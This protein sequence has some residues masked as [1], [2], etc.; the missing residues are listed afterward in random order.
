MRR[1]FAVYVASMDDDAARAW[2]EREIAATTAA[3]ARGDWDQALAAFVAGLVLVVAACGNHSDGTTH[4]ETDPIGGLLGG[5]PPMPRPKA[6]TVCRRVPPPVLTATL[7]DAGAAPRGLL[8]YSP[9]AGK[10][11]VEV[12]YD[13]VSDVTAPP[14]HEGGEVPHARLPTVAVIGD[15]AV[16][17]GDPAHYVVTIARIE[18]RRAGDDTSVEEFESM[19]ELLPA[20][21]GATIMGTVGPTGVAGET[22][23]CVSSA[24]PRAVLALDFVRNAVPVWPLLPTE[25]VPHGRSCGP[26]T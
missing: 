26:P 10:Q 8:R 16:T 17:P 11:H 18:A 5:P 21:K 15:V 7:V 12:M 25:P 22:T 9:R 19:K 2:V 23:L 3:A 13:R 6:E 20:A 1:D 14:G 4:H 24:D